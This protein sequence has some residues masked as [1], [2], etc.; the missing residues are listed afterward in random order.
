MNKMKL[1][2]EYVEEGKGKLVIPKEPVYFYHFECEEHSIVRVNGI[3]S[4]SM[5]DCDGTYKNRFEKI[6]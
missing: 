2:K 6:I 3:Y 5:I 1:S 4:E